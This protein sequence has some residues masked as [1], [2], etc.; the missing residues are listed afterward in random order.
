[1]IG[2]GGKQMSETELMEA[3]NGDVPG[4]R[5]DDQA[6][7]QQALVEFVCVPAVRLSRLGG[8]VQSKV[9]GGGFLGGPARRC[10]VKARQSDGGSPAIA[11]CSARQPPVSVRVLRTGYL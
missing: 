7:A 5:E 1:M 11:S 10:L 6:K 9:P 2:V 3:G 4:R 8:D